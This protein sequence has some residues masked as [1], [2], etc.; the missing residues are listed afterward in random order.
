M[1]KKK[2]SKKKNNKQKKALNTKNIDNNI[3]PNNL[4]LKKILTLFLIS[5]ILVIIFIIIK[6]DYSIFEF[7][8]SQHYLNM[9]EFGYPE[10]R[11]YAFF[12]LYPILIKLFTFII[13]S[14]Q[15]S[16]F[17]ISNIASFLSVLNLDVYLIAL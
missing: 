13:P 12:P 15:I 3:K 2:T 14:Y 1:S 9:A 17:L 6:H 5:R 16:G 4:S 8:D 7:F 10:P 11:L